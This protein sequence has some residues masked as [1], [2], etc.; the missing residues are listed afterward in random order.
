[1]RADQSPCKS[2]V[3]ATANVE[4]YFEQPP[5]YFGEGR[6]EERITVLGRTTK[7]ARDFGARTITRTTPAGR[8][9]RASY[10]AFGRITSLRLDDTLAPITRSYDARGFL[11]SVT[12]G[13]A[14]WSLDWNE[15]N[16]LERIT[17]NLGREVEYAFDAGDRLASMTR[18]GVE[19]LFSFA[20]DGDLESFTMPLGG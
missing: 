19:S 17:D 8:V 18:G 5:G 10:D 14:N 11:E 1:M 15:Q 2:A 9:Q 4:W 3:N 7:V 12:L 6:L 16:L 20:D 13:T